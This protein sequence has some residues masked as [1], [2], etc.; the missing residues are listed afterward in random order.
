MLFRTEVSTL[1]RKTF[2]YSEEEYRRFRSC[3]IRYLLLFSLL[4]MAH[5]CTR[6]N[7]T[8][9]SAAM[10]GEL[11]WTKA[12]IGVLSSALFWAYGIG[13]LINGRFSEIVGPDRF[14]LLSVT[15]SAAANFLF[16]FQTSLAV[17]AVIWAFNGYFQ[18]MAWAPG[19]AVLTR[20][21]PGDRRGFAV[22]FAHAFSGFGQVAA[23]LAVVAAFRLMPGLGWRAAF[24]L[25]PLVP[26]VMLLFFA[27]F[28]KCSPSAVGLPDYLEEKPGRAEAEEAMQEITRQHGKLYPYRYML[29]S[30]EFIVWC[31][32]ALLAGLA[33]YG[34]TTWIPLYFIDNYGIDLSVG[35]LRS[36][37]L[38]LGMGIGTLTVPTLTDRFCPEDRIPAV[39]ISAAA[40]AAS[41]CAFRFIDPTVPSQ[42]VLI[43]ITLFLAGFFIY[44]IYGTSL[45]HAADIGGRVFSG[46][47]SGILNFSAYA[48]AAIQSLT[49]GFLLEKLGWATVFG[50]MAVFCLV[51]AALG[52]MTR[53][54]KTKH[55]GE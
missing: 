48:G 52:I 21:W 42:T 14:V 20:W 1:N 9:A 34:L 3:G 55:S 39:I 19:I 10:L 36:L 11:N 49:Y 47:C 17:M 27:L 30:P 24:V 29:S 12:D 2:G 28:A 35:L 37:A 4:Y 26:L 8:N 41:V 54:T 18:S 38:P 5:Y 51:I 43:E 13:Q 31:I 53:L 45:V 22:G 33:R 50:S 25:P 40:A 46:T 16:G 15:L 6:L 7:L 23:T 32:I 44:A